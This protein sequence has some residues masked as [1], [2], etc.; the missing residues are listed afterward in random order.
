MSDTTHR[1]T[2]LLAAAVLAGAALATGP[3]VP[4]SLSA[5]ADCTD[6]YEACITEAREKPAIIREMGYVECLAEWTGCVLRKL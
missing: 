2:R 3:G 1:V 4:G 5:E 6:E